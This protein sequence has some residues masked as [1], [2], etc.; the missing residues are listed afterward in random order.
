MRG[1]HYRLNQ[2]V[3]ANCNTFDSPIWKLGEIIDLTGNEYR[4]YQVKLDEAFEGKDVYYFPKSC[5]KS[6]SVR[7]LRELGL[8]YQATCLNCGNEFTKR[9][10]LDK[11]KVCQ[12]CLSSPQMVVSLP[13]QSR[14]MSR[15]VEIVSAI[16]SG[17]Q[18]VELAKK[19]KLSRQRISQI[20]KENKLKV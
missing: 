3:L 16:N 6:A 5:I 10:K 15:N 12:E 13:K 14:F 4:P 2:R 20:L 7:N 8:P 17:V 1:K 19:H 11:N 9:N 18:Q